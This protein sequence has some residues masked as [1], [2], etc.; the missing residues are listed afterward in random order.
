M[1]C[2]SMAAVAQFRGKDYFQFFYA[3]DN[4]DSAKW[5]IRSLGSDIKLSEKEQIVFL[6]LELA[7]KMD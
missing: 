5:D 6:A 2:A 4:L 1:E 3:A 7:L